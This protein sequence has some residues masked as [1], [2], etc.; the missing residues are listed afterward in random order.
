MQTSDF[1][2]SIARS[3]DFLRPNQFEVVI[4]PP[5]DLNIDDL[6]LERIC[7]N[8]N[9]IPVPGKNLETFE[10]KPA[11]RQKRR[12]AHSISYEDITLSFYLSKDLIEKRFFEEWLSL[13]HDKSEYNVNYYENY[14][15]QLLIR[16]KNSLG[17][18]YQ[19][20]EAY[21]TSVQA[22]DLDY[23]QMDT[24]SELIVTFTYYNW[25]FEE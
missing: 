14:I 17:K 1:L 18:F 25:T 24:I 3:Q 7:L 21:P 23:N 22:I 5:K 20:N 11:G 9:K 16:P 12:I 15:G 10:Y 4:I 8:C 19:L 13:T 2:S 6:S